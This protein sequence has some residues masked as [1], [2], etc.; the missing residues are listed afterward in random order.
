MRIKWIIASR[1]GRFLRFI[2]LFNL[3]IVEF[4]PQVVATSSLVW[5]VPLLTASSAESDKSP[6]RTSL[7]GIWGNLSRGGNSSVLEGD[8]NASQ[9]VSGR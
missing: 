5:L 2:T 7:E 1:V 8:A 6:Q 3:D 4:P 9:R